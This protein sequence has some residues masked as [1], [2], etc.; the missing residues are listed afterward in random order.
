[1]SPLSC[2]RNQADLP[3]GPAEVAGKSVESCSVQGR[4]KRYTVHGICEGGELNWMGHSQLGSVGVST[5]E[6]TQENSAI[7]VVNQADFRVV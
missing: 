1:M 2:P 4:D 6:Q 5:V 7:S 3:H